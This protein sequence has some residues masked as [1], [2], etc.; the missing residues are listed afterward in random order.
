MATQ[1]TSYAV[2]DAER[3]LWVGQTPAAWGDVVRS[4]GRAEAHDTASMVAAAGLD[5]SVEQHPLEALVERESQSLRRTGSARRREREER[6][7]PVLC[8]V[9][10]VGETIRAAPER[11]GVRVLRRDHYSGEAHLRRSTSALSGRSAPAWRPD[12]DGGQVPGAAGTGRVLLDGD[13]ERRGRTEQ[14]RVPALAQSPQRR[15]VARE[16]PRLCRREPE[17]ARGRLPVDR[18]DADGERPLFVR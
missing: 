15:R 2:T 8:V 1:T 6:H 5:W 10:V 4:V 11:G 17:A 3:P 12:R 14:S 7:A 18:A 9:G 13:L 16:V